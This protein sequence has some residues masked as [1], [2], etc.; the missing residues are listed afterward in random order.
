[1]LGLL[2]LLAVVSLSALTLIGIGKSKNSGTGLVEFLST[3]GISINNAMSFLLITSLVSLSSKSIL[4]FMVTRKLFNLMAGIQIRLN[5]DYFR[6]IKLLEARR[7]MNLTRTSLPISMSEGAKCAIVG[8]LGFSIVFI[9]EALLLFVLVLPILILFPFILLILLLTFT[10]SFY[11]MHK[12]VGQ[13]AQDNGSLKIT[14]ENDVRSWVERIGSLSFLESIRLEKTTLDNKLDKAIE[15]AAIANVKLH[16][17]QQIPK[18]FLELV[19]VVAGALTIISFL[20]ISDFDRAIYA[21]TL[22]LAISFRVV[23]SILRMQGAILFIK[24]NLEQGVG[25]LVEYIDLKDESSRNLNDSFGRMN[26]YDPLA[27]RAYILIENLSFKFA[28]SDEYLFSRLNC[29]FGPGG[30]TLI[31]GDSGKGKTTLVNLILSHEVPESG[32][33]N[34]ISDKPEGLI[35]AYMPQSTVLIPGNL[36]ENVAIGVAKKDVDFEILEEVLILSGL[37]NYDNS[38]FDFKESNPDGFGR[39]LSGGEVQRIGLARALYLKPDILILDEPTSALDDSTENSIINN[40][41]T[42]SEIITVIT[43]SHSSKYLEL[44]DKNIRI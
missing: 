19:I 23:P 13:I 16:F 33:V 7:I 3:H 15:E 42:I 40:I 44:A 34:Y 38:K 22:L 20:L 2:D 6:L 12:K 21:G 4:S 25:F 30:L 10:A 24:S 37:A 41:K 35:I 43:I 14:S 17:I 29:K 26:T 5:L 32:I 1:M 11:L 27:S 36:V 39:N 9:S 18:Y 28:D 31:S 8:V